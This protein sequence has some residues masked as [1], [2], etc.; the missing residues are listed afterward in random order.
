MFY[1]IAY[2]CL[3][4]RFDSALVCC[5]FQGYQ[6]KSY[7]IGSW[8]ELQRQPTDHRTNWSRLPHLHRAYDPYAGVWALSGKDLQRWQRFNAVILFQL[9]R[10]PTY[11][12]AS[13]LG[14]RELHFGHHFHVS[15]ISSTPTLQ[16]LATD[17]SQ[18]R[19]ETS[20]ARSPEGRQR[21][22]Q[23]TITGQHPK[24]D[25]FFCCIIYCLD[26]FCRISFALALY[27]FT[28][29]LYAAMSG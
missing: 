18:R 11:K 5:L 21:S 14:F 4:F 8:T 16:T 26:I 1:F 23:K 28:V 17:Q 2:A 25:Y 10:S 7:G 6:V 29:F 9:G 19:S 22:K 15:F 3:F 12:F 24:F 20:E 13:I 27:I